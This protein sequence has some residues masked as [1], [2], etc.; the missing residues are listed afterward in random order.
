[1]VIAG[2][3]VAKCIVLFALVGQPDAPFIVEPFGDFVFE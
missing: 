2:D 3:L 1:L